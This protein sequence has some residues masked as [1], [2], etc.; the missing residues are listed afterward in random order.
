MHRAEPI[1]FLV[2]CFHFIKMTLQRRRQVDRQ[3]RHAVLR[4]FA[5]PHHDPSVGEIHIFDP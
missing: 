2:L 5:I 1:L 3:H 4:P